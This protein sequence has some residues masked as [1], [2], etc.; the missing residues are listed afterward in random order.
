[1]LVS[2]FDEPP[3]ACTLAAC[4]RP[5][6]SGGIDLRSISLSFCTFICDGDNV[7]L[8]DSGYTFIVRLGSG[9]RDLG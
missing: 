1:M 8:D 7:S 4:N 6:A 5:M 9:V 3:V 2:G